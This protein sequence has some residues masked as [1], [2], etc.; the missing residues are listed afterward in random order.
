VFRYLSPEPQADHRGV[1]D[2]LKDVHDRVVL[3]RLL[4]AACAPI[5]VVVV[6]QVLTAVLGHQ[7]QLDPAMHFLGGAAVAFF[8]RR[9]LILGANWFG[10]PA[11]AARA[12]IVF[13]MASTAALFWE[14]MEFL[15]GGTVG[16]SQISLR[17]TMD[18][19]LLGCAGAV[20]FL[21]I[22]AIRPTRSP[23]SSAGAGARP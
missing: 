13:C 1:A 10:S 21:A 7:A 15:A 16:Y 20:V 19:L 8:C 9:A 2:R 6:H 14:F 23:R 5:S 4:L 22:R 12:L 17:E 18:D 11:P 3:R